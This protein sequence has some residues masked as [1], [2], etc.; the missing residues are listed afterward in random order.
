MPNALVICL[1]A[2]FFSAKLLNPWSRGVSSLQNRARSSI[3]AALYHWQYAALIGR[4]GLILELVGESVLD[5][6]SWEDGD[7]RRPVSERRTKAMCRGNPV[8]N[9]IQVPL[10][11]IPDV[12]FVHAA[13]ELAQRGIAQLAAFRSRKEKVTTLD[14]RQALI[15]P[16][17]RARQWHDMILSP[18]SCEP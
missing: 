4:F 11:S 2:T 17:R 16:D 5:D 10:S 15:E 6:L 1:Y 8:L 18:P 9:W 7:F 14:D 13:D 3:S 12:G